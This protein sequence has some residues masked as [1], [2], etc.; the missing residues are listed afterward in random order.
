MNTTRLLS[1]A[2]I[3]LLFNGC[4]TMG[5]PSQEEITSLPIIDYGAAVPENGNYVLRFPAGKPIPTPVSFTG[6]LFTAPDK[7]ELSVAPATDIYTY[8]DWIS[9]DGKEWH[10]A[11]EHLDLKVELE[12]PGYYRPKPGYLKLNLDRKP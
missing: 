3:L 6:N 12:L 9:F 1:L 11:E 8:K 5:K 7:K 10:N 4:A 2:G